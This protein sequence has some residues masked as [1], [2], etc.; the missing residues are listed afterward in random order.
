MCDCKKQIT[1]WLIP[2]G[3]FIVTGAITLMPELTNEEWLKKEQIRIGRLG[4]STEIRHE[5][6]LGERIALFYANGYFDKRTGKWVP[7]AKVLA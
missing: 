3:R 4:R 6:G 2:G 5:P 1:R 7:D